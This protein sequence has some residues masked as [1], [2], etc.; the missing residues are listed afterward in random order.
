MVRIFSTALLLYFLP[1]FPC[2]SP[3][4]TTSGLSYNGGRIMTEPVSVSLIWF[5]TG[6]N[7]SGKDAIRNAITSLT[8]S[9]YEDSEVPTLGD[10]WDVIRQYKDGSDSPVTDR[11]DVG[12]ECFFTGPELNMTF[13][14]VVEIGQTV[15]NQTAIEGFGE[16]LSCNRVFEAD[17]NSIYHIVFSYTVMFLV[18]Q[19]QRKMMDMCNGKFQLEIFGNMTVNMTWAREPQKPTDHCSNFISGSYVGPPNGNEKIDSLVGYMLAKIAEEVTDRDGS[20]WNS[21]DG[22]GLTVSSY[23]ISP[24]QKMD[25]GPPLYTDEDRKISFNAVGLNGYRYIIPY[26]WNQKIRNCALK[27]SEMCSSK[28]ILVEHPRGHLKGGIVVNHTDGLQ[29][30][31]PNQKCQWN[32]QLPKEAKFISFTINYLAVAQ[33]SDDHLLICQSHSILEKCSVIQLNNGE[34]NRKFKVLG[35]R[36]SIEFTSGDHVPFESRGWELS[37]S[38]GL[39]DGREDVYNRDGTIGYASSTSFSYVQGL[40]CQWILH[41]KPG[42]L[43]SLSFIHINI[44]KDLDFIAI[45]NGT[46][47]QIANFSGSY[48]GYDLPQMNLT[49]EVKIVFATQTDKGEGWSAKYHISSPVNQDKNVLLVIVIVVIAIVAVSI[50]LAFIILATLKR[51]RMYNSSMNSDEGLMLIRVNTRREENR[52]GEGP[53][54]VVYRA[55]STNGN[56]VAVK[57]RRDIASQ[58][59]MEE[60]ILFKTSSHPNIV[61]LL[62][63]TQDGLSRRYLVFEFM[64]RGDLSWNLRE[65]GGALNWDK[66]L[67]IA[68]QICSA[69]QML[70]MYTKPPIYHGNI[71]SENI[72]LDE[73]CNAK[74]GGFG[75]ANYCSSSSSNRTNPE[76]TSEMAEDIWSFGLLL[77]ELLRGDPIMNRGVYKNLGSLDQINELVGGRECLDQRLE[78]PNDKIIGLAKFGEIAKWCIGGCCRVEQGSENSPKV[79]DV[80]S[81][82]RQVKQLFSSVLV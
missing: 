55:G 48:S 10:W 53:S 52:I 31:A 51:K 22:T 63:Y 66:R 5:G 37:Y 34:F 6:W 15:F 20:G 73:F 39:C 65:R 74:L 57:A 32:I 79:V 44:S 17:E 25:S 36:A 29:P 16:N 23:C 47:Q 68:L 12:A 14:Q 1:Q 3:D 50:S 27:S 7:E 11:V 26:I 43:V 69:I 58:T 49:G 2:L 28:A 81:S 56:V 67:T 75:T 45:Y 13:D 42:T 18:G 62:G 80:L 76:P 54:A 41:G 30:Y 19:K 35:S 24:F 38:A 59:E 71:A 46:R 82:L 40:S 78:I 4:E 70:H 33:G 60:E 9:P 64:Q 77:V 8:P 61:S 21:N 72:L